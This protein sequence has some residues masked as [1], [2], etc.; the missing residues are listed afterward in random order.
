MEF[1]GNLRIS[2]EITF[3]RENLGKPLKAPQRVAAEIPKILLLLIGDPSMA[4]A[5]T[6]L[7]HGNGGFGA[8]MVDFTVFGMEF[9][10]FPP[11]SAFWAGNRALAGRGRKQQRNPCFS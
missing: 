7:F 4:R 9:G 5:Q 2:P 11:F 3:S 8:Q 6:P 10:E 1:T